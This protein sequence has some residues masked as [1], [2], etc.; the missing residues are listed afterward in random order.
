MTHV[1]CR[2]TAKYR[3]QLQ[4]P[5]YARYSSTG[6]L[7]I[8]FLT[9]RNDSSSHERRGKNKALL[10]Y[11]SAAARSVNAIILCARNWRCCGAAMQCERTVTHFIGVSSMEFRHYCASYDVRSAA[12]E[13]FR[14]FR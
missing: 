7:Y 10:N 9:V 6:Y 2:L 11:F 1:T 14:R 5:T 12:S 13:F 8:Y 4:N 3:D